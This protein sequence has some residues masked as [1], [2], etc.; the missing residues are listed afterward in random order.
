MSIN[1][2]PI[3]VLHEMDDE[4]RLDWCMANGRNCRLCERIECIHSMNYVQQINEEG[5]VK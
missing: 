2:N 5:E 3:Q 4:S 1:Y